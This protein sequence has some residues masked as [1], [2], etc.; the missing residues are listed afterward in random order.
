[1]GKA[2]GLNTF[3]ET[4]NVGQTVTGIRRVTT[5]LNSVRE[6]LYL[7]WSESQ[8]NF[9]VLRHENISKSS[10]ITELWRSVKPCG[11]Q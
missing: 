9:C 5:N 6:K 4:Q 1:M 8:M 10:E 3:V 7:V 11:L 2:C